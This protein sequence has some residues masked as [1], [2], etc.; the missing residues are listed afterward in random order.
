MSD[1]PL[2]ENSHSIHVFASWGRWFDPPPPGLDEPLQA[3]SGSTTDTAAA[4]V[5]K[6]PK[7]KLSKRKLDPVFASEG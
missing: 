3:P 1:S 2:S 7:T 5:G 6:K 4:S